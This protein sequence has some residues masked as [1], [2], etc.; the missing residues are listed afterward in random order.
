M[1]IS[2]TSEIQGHCVSDPLEYWDIR[3]IEARSCT[4]LAG[5]EDIYY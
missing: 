5:E 2:S 3:T 1:K 4:E